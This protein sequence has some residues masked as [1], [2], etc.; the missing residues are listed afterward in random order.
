LLE[1]AAAISAQLTDL[2]L[3]GA[4]LEGLATT[5]A[6]LIGRSV[7][8]EDAAFRVVANAQ[9]GSVDEARR[10]SVERGRSSPEL[11]QRLLDAGVYAALLERMGPIY[12]PPM[13]DLGGPPGGADNR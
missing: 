12:L 8:I 11:A 4:N 9:V 2:V 10:L 3:Q 1:K 13:P 6:G 7:M 5:L